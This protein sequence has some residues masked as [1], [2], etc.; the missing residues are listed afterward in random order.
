M[1]MKDV[2]EANPI[3][4][5]KYAVASKIDEEPAF[6]WWV[7]YTLKRRG[8]IIA[9]V[10]TKYWKKTHKFYG[11]RLPKSAAEALQIDA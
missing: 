3:E 5:A 7:P 6:V 1:D 2:K 11:V 10:K 9:K 8:R 4:L